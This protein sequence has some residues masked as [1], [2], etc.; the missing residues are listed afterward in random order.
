MSFHFDPPLPPPPPPPPPQSL[1]PPLLWTSYQ[2]QHKFSLAPFSVI[3][4]VMADHRF[5]YAHVQDSQYFVLHN[6]A[7]FYQEVANMISC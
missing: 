4:Y 3:S 6:T 7:K 1:D 5:I 2:I